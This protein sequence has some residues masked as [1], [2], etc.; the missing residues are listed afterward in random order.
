MNRDFAMEMRLKRLNPELHRRFADAVVA[1]QYNL[2]RY[3]LIFPEFTDHTN[4][5]SMTV[6]DFA[7]RL[8]GDQVERMSADEIYALLMGSY[9][10]DAGMGI[11]MQDYRLFSEQIDFGDYFDTHSRE[12]YPAIIR[13]FHHEYSGLFI[14]KYEGLFEFPSEAH[15]RAVI[16]IARGHRKTDLMDEEEY[17]PAFPLPGGG[18]MCLPYLAAL[19]RLADEIDISSERNPILLYD[20]GDYTSASELHWYK[21]TR[22]VRK[23]AVSEREFTI[24]A[25]TSDPELAAHVRD[26]AGKMQGTLDTCRRA[27][28]GRSPYVITQERVVLREEQE[29]RNNP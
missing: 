4:L 23:V 8:I 16:Q 3:K 17:P 27:V 18:S 28:C 22:A 11:S 20:A 26:I 25:D 21:L 10:H 2:S 7:N 6:I 1:L 24:V 13:G 15:C 29:V 19:I 12:D 5:H 14:R 9:L